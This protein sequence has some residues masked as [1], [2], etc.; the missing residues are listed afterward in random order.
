MV[1]KTIVAQVTLG[2]NPS[3]SATGPGQTIIAID[4]AWALRGND[5]SAAVGEVVFGD[6]IRIVLAI[7]R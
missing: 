1:S 3:P 5:P 2:S 6:V 4:L 7:H